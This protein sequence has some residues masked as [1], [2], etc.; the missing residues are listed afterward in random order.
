MSDTR[1]V[2]VK[3]RADTT[4]YT[5]T[6]K[7]ASD[8]TAKFDKTQEK[9][10]RNAER[11]KAIGMASQVGGAAIAAGLLAATKAASDQEQAM[12]SLTA[13]FKANSAQMTANAQGA[14]KLGLSTTTY[15]N[16]AR[17]S[18][19]ARRVSRRR[20]CRTSAS[21]SPTSAAL[22][23][24]SSARPRISPPSSAAPRRKPSTRWVLRC[25]VRRTRRSATALRCK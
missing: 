7:K 12:G 11:W 22:P 16:A 17:G 6:M 1:T 9:A 5:T 20:S 23:T 25:V 21:P 14:S 8:T 15:A 2:A 24:I 18:T 3:L 13:V 19:A 10:Q 4:S